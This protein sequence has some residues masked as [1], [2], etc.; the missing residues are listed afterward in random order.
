M[1]GTAAQS[2]RSGVPA[3]ILAAYLDWSGGPSGA[4]CMFL[5]HISESPTVLRLGTGAIP[6]APTAEIIMWSQQD[7]EQSLARTTTSAE[8]LI[9]DLRA[10]R[11]MPTNWDGEGGAQ[12]DSTS[13]EAA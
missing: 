6:I 8:E 1:T 9:A 3:R 2:R 13:I 4:G 7:E 5:G 10:Y 11:R 12:P